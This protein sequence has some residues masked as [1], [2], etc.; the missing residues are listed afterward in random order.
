MT[1]PK[2][3]LRSTAASTST[4]LWSPVRCAKFICD[5]ASIAQL[6][7]FLCGVHGDLSHAR[8]WNFSVLSVYGARRRHASNHEESMACVTPELFDET[9]FPIQI[10]LHRTAIDIGALIGTPVAM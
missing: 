4:G 1:F 2:L 5:W 10:G 8:F 7:D 6:T 3:D 9:I